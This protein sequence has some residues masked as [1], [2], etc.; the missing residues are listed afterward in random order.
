MALGYE[1][2]ASLKVDT[3]TNIAL[4]TGA[5]VP[6]GRVSLESSSGYGGEIVGPTGMGIGLPEEYDWDIYD[7]SIDVDL[8]E[9]FYTNQIKEWIFNR[10]KAGVVTISTRNASLQSFLK[11]YW[12]SIS[13]SS[14]EASSV[15]AS[16]G[17]VALE[18]NSYAIGGD[19]IGNKEGQLT[20]NCAAWGGS[21]GTNALN[22]GGSNI[23]PIPYWNT[24]V[25]IDAIEVP[26]LNWTVDLS[27]E[28]VKFFS[29]E[30][31]VNPVE[32]RFVAVG[33]MTVTFTGDYMFVD[34]GTF[35][36]PDT[37][38]SLY[39]NIGGD[40]L[41]ME[42]LQLRNENDAVQS[43][44]ALVPISVEYAAFELVV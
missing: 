20:D 37:L 39:V 36:S 31:N 16:V 42:N 8:S 9:D 24:F 1:G 23:N 44:D 22:P 38:T 29:C 25:E 27:Q 17:F 30:H 11:C 32:P 15:T 10:Q 19:Y 43:Q 33:P 5:S 13:I 2:Y 3:L 18:R 34:T 14:S 4:C 26:F 21:T 40:E 12:N 28:V 35:L 41:K 7:G 6:K